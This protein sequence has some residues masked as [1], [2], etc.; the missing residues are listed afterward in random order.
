MTC[1]WL[2]TPKEAEKPIFEFF[3]FLLDID[4]KRVTVPSIPR[5]SRPGGTSQLQ[6]IKPATAVPYVAPRQRTSNTDRGSLFF[7][8]VRVRL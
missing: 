2:R 3:F 5:L 4:R 6:R 8:F 7:S 1:S